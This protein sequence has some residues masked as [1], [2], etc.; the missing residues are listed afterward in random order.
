MGLLSIDVLNRKGIKW[1]IFNIRLL[2]KK[3]RYE[4]N[5]LFLNSDD[6]LLLYFNVVIPYIDLFSVKSHL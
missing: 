6:M 2:F 1:F 4:R 5:I 3:I